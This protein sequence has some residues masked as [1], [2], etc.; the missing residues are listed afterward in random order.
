MR[1]FSEGR[2]GLRAMRK[3]IFTRLLE[4]VRRSRRPD[5]IRVLRRYR[6]LTAG[7]ALI[8]PASGMTKYGPATGSGRNTGGNTTLARAI[9]Q[10]R[11]SAGDE[12]A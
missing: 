4:A 7:Q 1:I 5:A 8:R 9:R 3:G 12:F 10:A 2:S 11:R 6:H